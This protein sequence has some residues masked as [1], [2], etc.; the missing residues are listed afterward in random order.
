[1]P[2][3]PAKAIVVPPR[4]PPGPA[5]KAMLGLQKDVAALGPGRRPA[6]RQRLD[7][8]TRPIAADGRAAILPVVRRAT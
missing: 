6:S 1:M 5:F 7:G 2:I 4:R 3:G 8:A